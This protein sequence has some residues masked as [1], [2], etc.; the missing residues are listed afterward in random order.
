MGWLMGFFFVS[1]A[2]AVLTIP[3]LRPSIKTSP[4]TLPALKAGDRLITVFVIGT[5]TVA[6]LY[7]LTLLAA[8][9]LS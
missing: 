3:A 1:A 4:F 6:S 7:G 9:I 5:F 2:M 8:K